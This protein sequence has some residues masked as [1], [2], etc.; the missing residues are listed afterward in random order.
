[1]GRLENKVA[2]ITGAGQGI[3]RGVARAFAAEG[4]HVVVANRTR[5]TGEAVAAAIKQNFGA[6]DTKALYVETDVAQEESIRK[7]VDATVDTF[8]RVDILVNNATPSGGMARL[9]HMTQETMEQH[10]CVNYYGPF[11]GPCR[12]PSLI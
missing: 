4:A 2:I 11:W 6:G 8:G 10:V 3:G 5:E 1:M 7:M 12:Q 9:E